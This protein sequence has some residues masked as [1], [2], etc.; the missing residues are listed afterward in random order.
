MGVLA[1]VVVVAAGC[2][3]GVG[4]YRSVNLNQDLDAATLARYQ[5]E[6]K[7]LPAGQ[8][9]GVLE[10]TNLWPLGLL[11]YWHQGTVRV[12]QGMDGK[13]IY[14]IS[15]TDGYGPLS[16]FWVDGTDVMYGADGKRFNLME[17]SSVLGC[18]FIMFHTM[19]GLSPE[20]L[21]MQHSSTHLF[22]HAINFGTMHGETS[23][24]LITAPGPIGSG[25]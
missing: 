1:V 22:C 15:A 14:M 8:H 18:H 3:G 25:R 7:Q 12:M 24:S 11:A 5:A 9:M 6:A 20:G 10:H 17:M 13:P 2:T 16:L 19:G 4:P 21:W 23:W